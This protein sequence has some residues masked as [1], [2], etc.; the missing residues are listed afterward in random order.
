MPTTIADD[1]QVRKWQAASKLRVSPEETMFAGGESLEKLMNR[2]EMERKRNWQSLLY[3]RI[4]V[5][6]MGECRNLTRGDWKL[7]KVV[8]MLLR[9]GERRKLWLWV[10]FPSTSAASTYIQ[11]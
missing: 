4:T 11:G 7:L 6:V 10:S 1:A 3:W 8:G 5:S 2:L 9:V